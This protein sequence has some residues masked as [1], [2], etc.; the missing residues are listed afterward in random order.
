MFMPILAKYVQTNE[1]KQGNSTIAMLKDFDRVLGEEIKATGFC[2]PEPG[3]TIRYREYLIKG[4]S[5]Q[6]DAP[7]SLHLWIKFCRYQRLWGESN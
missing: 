1:R 3:D 6:A 4:G 2:N 7:W 5:M